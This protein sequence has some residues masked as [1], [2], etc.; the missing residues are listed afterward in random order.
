M[1]AEVLVHGAVI[2][3]KLLGISQVVIGLTIVAL[4]TSLPE[5]AASMVAAYRGQVNFI[6][7]AILGSNLFNILGITGTASILAP[8]N[9]QDTLTFID[10]LFLALSTLVFIMFSIFSKFLNKKLL[11]A[12]LISYIIYVLFL[13][14]GF[15][16][17]IYENH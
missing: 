2:T 15:N 12:I 16:R 9:T 13:F 7:G 14:L 6:L 5:V 3:A 4:G 17:Y 10:L 8:I 11:T 1:G